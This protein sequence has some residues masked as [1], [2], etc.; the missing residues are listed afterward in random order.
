MPSQ[1]H[2][3]L[4]RTHYT[5]AG[6]DWDSKAAAELPFGRWIASQEAARAL[7]FL[8][9]A[10]SGLTTGAI[11]NFDQPAWETVPGIMPTSGSAMIIAET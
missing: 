9:S 5:A 11:V 7:N 1:A 3:R 2:P 6:D 4:G 8:V 10:D